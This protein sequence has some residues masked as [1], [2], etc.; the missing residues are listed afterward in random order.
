MKVK[1]KKRKEFLFCQLTR[2]TT[3][4]NYN[5]NFSFNDNVSLNQNKSQTN[6][7]KNNA[8]EDRNMKKED[9]REYVRHQKRSFDLTVNSGK[10]KYSL[11]I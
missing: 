4:I 9:D 3:K 8:K 7:W 2:N 5:L 11:F 10:I 6:D 1:K